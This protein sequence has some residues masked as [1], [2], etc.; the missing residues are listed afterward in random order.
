MKISKG[1]FF[2]SQ[3]HY[4]GHIVSKEGVVVDLEKFKTIMEWPTL[5]NVAKIRSFM[6]MTRYYMRFIQNFSKIGYPIT[7][8]QNKGKKFE[9]TVECDASFDK[10]KKFLTN[11]PVLRI[12]NL[13]KNFVV[14]TN[15]YK[16][17]LGGVLMQ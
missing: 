9:W 5:K 3:T 2:Q 12:T 7:I 4:L 13:Y 1:N 17:G 14:C 16:E 15:A 6:G 10:L 8:L 11:A